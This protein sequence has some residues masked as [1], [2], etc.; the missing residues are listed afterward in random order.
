[1]RDD[2]CGAADH[3]AGEGVL[4]DA[5]GRVVEGAG[6]L[7]QQQHARVAQ[8]SARDRQPLLLPARHLHP[9]LANLRLVPAIAP[10]EQL[11]QLSCCMRQAGTRRLPIS[12][13]LQCM[14][15]WLFH[16][17]YNLAQAPFCVNGT[18][19]RLRLLPEQAS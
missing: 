7:V 6:G 14:A 19:A 18:I 13:V 3:E 11:R 16:R 5:L 8:Q 4:H 10:R 15:L 17:M 9:L 1:M 2:D 12:S